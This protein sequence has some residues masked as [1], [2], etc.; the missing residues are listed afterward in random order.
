MGSKPPATGIPGGVTQRKCP[1]KSGFGPVPLIMANHPTLLPREHGAYA[2]LAFPLI[3]GWAMAIPSLSAL[4]LGAS[5][6]LFFL[7]NESVAILLGVRGKRLH[8]QL[9]TPARARARTLMGLGAVLGLA[10]ILGAGPSVWPE[11]LLPAAPGALLIPTVLNGRQK[12]FPGEILVVTAFSTLVLP[13]AM[14]SGADPDRAWAAACVWWVSFTLGTLEVHAIKASHKPTGRGDWT[15]WGSPLLS[16]A[17]VLAGFAVWL[18]PWAFSG[19]SG[20][21][22]L[23]VAA[24]GSDP[25][26]FRGMAAALTRVLIHSVPA[27]LPPSVAVFGLSL[28]RVHPKHLKRVGWSLVGANTLALVILLAG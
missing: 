4:A 5:A 25:A 28:L 17:V 22:D 8:T 9:G 16:G 6:V 27:L 14:A 23:P 2:E 3:T 20:A 11:I 1:K 10:G 15:R 21:G 24:A 18:G 19:V 7:A 26:W 12:T 13:L